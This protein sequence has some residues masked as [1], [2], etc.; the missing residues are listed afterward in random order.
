VKVKISHPDKLLFPDDGVTKADLADYYERVAEWM[1]PHLR[2]RPVSMQRFPDGIG[3]KGFFHKD[4][5]DYFPDWIARAELP[6]TDGTVT[7]VLIQNADTLRYLANQNTITPHVFLSRADRPHQPD[8]LVFDLDPAEGSDFATVRRAARWTAELLDELDLAPFAQ[9][10]GSKGIHIWTPLRRRADTEG[11]KA[12]ANGAAQLLAERHPEALT[13]E[14]RKAKRGGRILVDVAR[15]GYAQTAVPPYAVRPRPGAPVATPIR[16]DELS[17]S[18]L[19]P[20]RW[21]LR[22][23]LRRLGSE[24]DP[25]ADVQAHARG[26][27]E[28]RKR[29]A[30]LLP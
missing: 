15:N 26:L 30:K 17:N 1:L 22:N 28:P 29:L 16:L 21:T 13:T 25:W 12:F 10:T 7:H 11:V 27:G 8:R 5:P 6:K 20:D 2:D 18:R 23:V 4:A 14:F 3:G 19:R 9:V 24:G